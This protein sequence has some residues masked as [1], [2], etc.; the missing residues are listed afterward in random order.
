M[1]TI[2]PSVLTDWTERVVAS[3][4][5]PSDIA[6]I[7]ARSLVSGDLRGHSSHGI[8]LLPKY[9][10][11]V[12]G[13]A[14][15]RIDPA[16]RPTVEKRT[17][18]RALLDGNDAYGRVVGQDATEL[19][20]ELADDHGLAVVGVRDGNHLGRMGEW[21]EVAAEAGLLT[22]TFVKAEA[23]IVAP[24][25]SGKPRLSTN[26]IAAGIPTFDAL[27][28]PIVLDVA[29][30]VAAGG[31]VWERGVT[32]ADVPDRWLVDADGQ[33]VTD[34]DAYD[35]GDAALRPLGGTTAGH[36]GFGLAVVAELVGA[37]L[38]NG[39]VAG[40]RDHVP[41]TNSVGLIAVDPTWFTVRETVEERIRTFA[42]Y[43]RGADSH[44][45]LVPDVAGDEML[46]PGEAEHRHEMDNRR[47]GLR[48]PAETVD[49]LNEAAASL[50]CEP[51]DAS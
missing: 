20:I 32:D 31:K 28:F 51:L 47:T 29:T 23:S 10:D 33:P 37:L 9:L 17:G 48:L 25:G 30:S 14:Q 36:K 12:D 41:F 44:S 34:P 1:P 49:S 26:P 39:V 22:L 24:V 4:G 2:Q 8:R 15:N 13:D 5:A 38:G 50:R 46:L 42:E 18:P 43:I 11:R 19:A 21:A 35:S 7:V 6:R 3:A 16:A 27:E 40:D 45:H